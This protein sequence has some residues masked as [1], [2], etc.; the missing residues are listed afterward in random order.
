MG[1][2]CR[3]NRGKEY[4]QDIGVKT[5]RKETTRKTKTSVDNIKIDFRE[6]GLGGMG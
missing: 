6:I 1:R 5:R 3:E 4:M 2:A